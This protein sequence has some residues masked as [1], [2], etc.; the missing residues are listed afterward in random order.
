MN[1]QGAACST[2]AP[3]D[4][5]Q[6][7]GCWGKAPLSHRQLCAGCKVHRACWAHVCSEAEGVCQ[8]LGR[9]QAMGFCW[10]QGVF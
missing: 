7:V 6:A 3:A 8:A 4:R 10:A 2:S 5:G 9:C 1:V